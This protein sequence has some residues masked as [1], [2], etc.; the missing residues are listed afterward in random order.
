MNLFRF[1]NIKKSFV[2][3][4][5]C[6]SILEKERE[7]RYLSVQKHKSKT[8]NRKKPITDI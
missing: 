4:K 5:M 3:A 2:L 8:K 6:A 1:C 7:F